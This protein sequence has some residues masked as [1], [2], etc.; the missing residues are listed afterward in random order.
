MS[1]QQS[2]NQIAS[3]IE[4]AGRFF[5]QSPEAKQKSAKRSIEQRLQEID[6][7]PDFD[8]ITAEEIKR[9]RDLNPEFYQDKTDEEI[10]N[11]ADVAKSVDT[12]YMRQLKEEEA[13][14]Y[15]LWKLDPSAENYAKYHMAVE[16]RT[17]QEASNRESNANKKVK[18]NT[19]P[20]AKREEVLAN[21]GEELLNRAEQQNAHTAFRKQLENYKSGGQV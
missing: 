15:D 11:L 1:I 3:N 21:T 4:W 12:R 10:A 17:T 8:T 14:T 18:I 20:K 7:E 9:V 13:L 6:N 5:A 2:V 16:N 19:Q